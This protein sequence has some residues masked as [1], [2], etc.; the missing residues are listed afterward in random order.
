MLCLPQSSDCWN[1]ERHVVRAPPLEVSVS[2]GREKESC[3]ERTSPRQAAEFIRHDSFCLHRKGYIFQSISHPYGTVTAIDTPKMCHQSG[4]A[5]RAIFRA[6]PL[7]LRVTSHSRIPS[8]NSAAFGVHQSERS[9]CSAWLR[10]KRRTDAGFGSFWTDPGM[11]AA[12]T[13]VL[14]VRFYQSRNSEAVP[15]CR[16]VVGWVLALMLIK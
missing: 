15:V 16:K 9:E 2:E 8:E 10:K 14:Q 13:A 1:E 3:T 12:L 7:A 4:L 11:G 5:W 6:R